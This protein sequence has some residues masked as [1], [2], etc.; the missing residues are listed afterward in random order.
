[1]RSNWFVSN[2]W[3]PAA[4]ITSHS[5]GYPFE[6]PIPKGGPIHGVIL[7]DQVKSLDW[8]ARGIRAAG[9]A[10]S[11]VVTETLGKLTALLT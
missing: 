2:P 9:K 5:K 1:M 3:H 7:A 11:I 6:V 4:P 10:P 8:K